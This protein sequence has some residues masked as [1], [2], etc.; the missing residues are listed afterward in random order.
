MA[1][2]GEVLA[3]LLEAHGIEIAFGIPGTHTIELYRGIPQTRIRHVTPRHEQGAG[4]MADGYARV[5]GKPA[6]C[7]T[8]SGPGAFNIATAMGQALQDSVPMLV[9]SADNNSWEKSLGEGRL[10]ET[11]NLQAA[12]AECSRWSHTLTRPDELPRILARAFAIFRSQRPG[13]VHLSLPLDVIT[14]DASHVAPDAWPVPSR[15]AADPAALAAAARLLNAAERPVIALGGGAA[16]IG[17]LAARLAERLDA[18]LT[19]THNAKGL[20]AREHPLHVAGSP[21]LAPVR[22]LYRDADVI[23]GIGTEFGE[24]D[25]DFFFKGD[26]ALGG[27]LVRIDIDALQLLRNV[28][29]EIAIQADSRLAVEALLPLL[30]SRERR[31]AERTRAACERLRALDHPGYQRVLD[32][33]LEALPEAIVIGD[34]TQPAYFAAAQ[35]HAR[36]ARRFAS[37]ATGYGTL[38]FA[39]PAAFGA[40]LAQPALPVIALIGDGGLQFTLNELSSGV[41]AEL[42]LAIVVWNNRRYEM[43]AQNFEAAGMEPIAC[44]IHTPDFLAIARAYG[45]RACRVDDH[46]TLIE[47]LREYLNHRVPTLIE[48]VEADFIGA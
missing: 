39:L 18:P 25:Y 31:G 44:D 36:A 38:G 27:K 1:S 24:T 48:L 28:R 15:P 29:P 19:C 32:T 37:A 4:F 13:P 5:C 12:M 35:F 16:D 2:C 33:L 41:E 3:L 26:F 40:R 47:A 8:V 9:I 11:R 23:L 10:H 30:E 34:S 7:I 21:S 6:L 14:A 46:A 43:I 45:C 20:L 22:E 42:S 17:V